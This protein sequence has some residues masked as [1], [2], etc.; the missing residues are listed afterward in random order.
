MKS[1]STIMLFFCSAML[2]HSATSNETSTSE[3]QVAKLLSATVLAEP[4][5]RVPP[6]YP[7]SAA[8]KSQEGW[9]QMSFVVN[10]EGEVIDPLIEDS[11]G[12]KSLEKSAMKAIKKWQYKPAMQDGKPIQQCH[13][14]VQLDYRLDGQLGVRPKFLSQYKS[15]SKA[16]ES[17]NLDD[18]GSKL[19]AINEKK[20]WNMKE[21]GWYWMLESEYARAVKD[22]KRELAALDR[23]FSSSLVQ[24]DIGK[25]MYVFLRERQFTLLVNQTQYPSALEVFAKLREI[26]DIEETIEHLSPYVTQI[27]NLL[28]SDK[29]ISRQGEIKDKGIWFHSLSRNQ[30]TLTDIQ[31]E[32]EQLDI[33]CDNKRSVYT[34]EDGSVF[35]IPAKWGNCRVVVE[36]ENSSTFT[37]IEL[38]N[39]TAP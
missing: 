10:E 22:D 9:V 27:Q 5:K 24:K 12:I 13:N 8:R 39:E 2:S 35:K 25:Q 20:M 28:N 15:I 14:R 11:S 18:A 36:G 17:N 23:V 3:P 4:I 30:F 1:I 26:S 29:P 19:A 7:K 6:K 33:R 16:I 31:G 21:T 37:V 38:A 32:L 34:V